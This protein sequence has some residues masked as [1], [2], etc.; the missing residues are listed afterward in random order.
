ML[1]SPK[2]HT[3][4]KTMKHTCTRRTV[5]GALLATPFVT[6]AWAATRRF[7]LDQD[8][9]EVRFSYYIDGSPGHCSIAVSDADFQ[10][11]LGDLSRSQVS[12]SL[13]PRRIRAGFLPATEAL[14][15]AQLLDASRHPVIRFNSRDIQASGAGGS[16]SGDL[17]IKGVTRAERLT[18]QFI[19]TIPDSSA[20]SFGIQLSGRVDRNAYG[21]SGYSSFV[22]PQVDLR[23][24]AYLNAA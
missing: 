2:F 6:P 5:M 8:R 16:V 1:E 3:I 14:K 15:S 18:A 10:V 4:L 7:V 19:N 9:S 22:G 24:R 13:D 21:V 20:A 12:V 11:D 23:I 17:S